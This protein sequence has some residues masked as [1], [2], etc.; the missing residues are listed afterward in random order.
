MTRSST[1]AETCGDARTLLDQQRALGAYLEALLRPVPPPAA[2]DPSGSS[3]APPAAPATLSA[4][5]PTPSAAAYPAWAEGGFECQL[6]QV[7]G[8]TL[9]LPLAHLD[10][11]L[12]WEDAAA[13]SA[14]AGRGPWF[15]GQR[16][17]RGSQVGL[18]DVAKL[19]LPPDRHAA[20]APA[21]GGRLGKLLL[22]DGGRWGL[23]CDAVAE[24]IRLSPAQVKWRSPAG[25]RPW[26]AGTVIQRMCAL[27]DS[28][29]L[30]AL[31]A[32]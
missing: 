13:V 27:I 6:F 7:A 4:V 15:L 11:V 28:A 16:A 8:L 24:V 31:L 3:A 26:L 17:H 25:S 32:G 29:A 20:L 12:P 18:V 21:D 1:P 22:I 23:A 19:V 5:A 10:G 14:P 9:A 30:A 2:P